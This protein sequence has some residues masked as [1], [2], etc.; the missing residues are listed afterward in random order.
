FEALARRE[1]ASVRMA[2]LE[3]VLEIVSPSPT[4]EKW[5]KFIARLVEAYAEERGLTM[6]GMGSTTFRKKA[7]KAGIEPD[8]CYLFNEEKPYP[9]L[10]IEVV[11]THGGLDRLEIYRRLGVR[12]VW[13]LSEEGIE[14]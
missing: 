12:E 11:V 2:Y 13:F 1:N 4:H 9:D 10:A 6:D 7:K 5:K 3:G 14:V 8:E